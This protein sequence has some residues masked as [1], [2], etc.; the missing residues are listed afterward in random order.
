M[1]KRGINIR[2]EYLDTTIRGI[3]VTSFGGFSEYLKQNKTIPANTMLIR[4]FNGKGYFPVFTDPDKFTFNLNDY[5]KPIDIAFINQGEEVIKIYKNYTSNSCELAYSYNVT[6]VAIM[7]AGE[8]DKI[9]IDLGTMISMLPYWTL[10]V[11]EE[12]QT[13][14]K[15]FSYGNEVFAEKWNKKYDYNERF[16]FNYFDHIWRINGGSQFSHVM[17]ELSLIKDEEV[18]EKSVALDRIKNYNYALAKDYQKYKEKYYRHGKCAIFSYNEAEN[19]A[20]RY[21]Y[22][23]G[24][25]NVKS[26]INIQEFPV[27]HFTKEDIEKEIAKYKDETLECKRIM[28]F[29]SIEE[30]DYPTFLKLGKLYQNQ[31]NKKIYNVLPEIS[32]VFKYEGSRSGWTLID[33]K[34]FS[35]IGMKEFS[36]DKFHEATDELREYFYKELHKQHKID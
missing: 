6:F 12:I 35:E 27:M 22:I 29:M 17:Q 18:L 31:E 25:I 7:Q 36:S 4:K 24:W 28:N 33:K 1:F 9:N 32:K 5:S 8:F 15:F 10:R 34:D 11:D 21:D 2:N 3:E 30:I 20:R 13:A 19:I 26:V 14:D 16:Y 23:N